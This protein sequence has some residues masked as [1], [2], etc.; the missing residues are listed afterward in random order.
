[1][2]KTL[3]RTLAVVV[4][5][6]TF[7]AMADWDPIWEVDDATGI[8]RIVNH[9]MHYPQLPDYDGWDVDVSNYM[10]ADDF[11]CTE[12]GYIADIHF[13][14]SWMGGAVDWDTVESIWVGIYDQMPGGPVG[15]AWQRTLLTGDYVVRPVE[16]PDNQGWLDPGTGEA[17]HPDHS[18]FD[19]VNVFI[20]EE[21]FE[22]T[23]GHVYWLAIHVQMDGTLNKFDKPFTV[24]WKN[25]DLEKQP[26]HGSEAIYLARDQEWYD[27]PDIV[28]LSFVITPEP[29][30][31]GLFGLGGLLALVR[32]RRRV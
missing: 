31:L 15:P 6:M 4:A 30:A 20:D 7:A 27:I 19:Q 12:N 23:K 16:N 8:K 13:W 18:E 24:G 29:S 22:Q 5:L 14:V 9:K 32:R 28:D 3:V 1:M 21:P 25:A 10:L 2:K 17:V 11:T 26:P